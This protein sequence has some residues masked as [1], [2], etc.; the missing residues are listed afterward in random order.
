MYIDLIVTEII[1]NLPHESD[2][3]TK[4]SRRFNI[5]QNSS[6]HPQLRTSIQSL[7][8]GYIHLLHYVGIAGSYTSF[9]AKRSTLSR[10]GLRRTSRFHLGAEIWNCSYLPVL[11]RNISLLMSNV[12]TRHW[13][14]LQQVLNYHLT[15]QWK[16]RSGAGAGFLRVLRFP[17]PIFI[18]PISPQSPSPI[19]WG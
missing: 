9:Q 7:I 12:V 2:G 3:I 8:T 17:L 10:P 16:Q 13:H 1:Q 14:L 4:N 6:R 5:T 19:T 11:Y 15:K 18:P